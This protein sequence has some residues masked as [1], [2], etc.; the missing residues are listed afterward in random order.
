MRTI[1]SGLSGALVALAL[2]AAASPATSATVL[3]L[4]WGEGCGKSTCF[5]DQGV[6]RKTFSAGD[7]SGPV[8]IGQ[9][10]MQRGVLGSLDGSM[11]KITF[12]L[13]GEE[14]GSWGHWS[15]GGIGGDELGF[16]GQELP[17]NP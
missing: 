1:R 17:W 5:D 15:M 16:T 10:L 13:N 6:Y 3:N 7:F 2:S 4:N 11:F 9:L 12:A 14:V 8:T